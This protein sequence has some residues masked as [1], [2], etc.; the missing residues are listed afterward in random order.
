MGLRSV[1]SESGATRFSTRS[2]FV[3]WLVGALVIAL[4]GG[5]WLALPAL[6]LAFASAIVA[7]MLVA[8]ARP[9][10]RYVGLSRRAAI[11]VGGTMLLALPL[12]AILLVGPVLQS[13][14]IQIGT[15]LPETVR[16]IEHDFNVSFVSIFKQATG[17]ESGL[18]GENVRGIISDAV[19]VGSLLL[20]NLGSAGSFLLNAIAALVVVIFGGFYLAFDV[21]HYRRGT[22]RLFPPRHHDKIERAL[23]NCG[24]ALQGWLKAQL[25]AMTAVGLLAGGTAWVLGLPAPLAVGF[26]AGLLEFFPI[27]GPWLGAV[28]M[29]LLA[30]GQGM[31][32][33]L[34]AAAALLVIQQLEA[35]VITPIAQERMAEIPP[36]VVL[37]GLIAFG[38]V[39]GLIGFI[40]A[41]PLTLVAYVLV[42]ELYVRDMLGQDV[43]VPGE[44]KP[45][46]TSLADAASN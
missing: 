26:I 30:F 33:L 18:G 31:Q 34:L 22:V 32:T 3:F 9:L 17:S 21:E 1:S 40:V 27:V 16:A 39:F 2:A 4:L 24:R 14:L 45:E 15:T 20:S 38:F 23:G 11:G 43:K 36:F 41:G 37:F 13:Q 42:N 12:I 25:I 35:N 5:I 29:L 44:A 10:Q 46:E 6:L 19:S 8:T 7:S 28:P